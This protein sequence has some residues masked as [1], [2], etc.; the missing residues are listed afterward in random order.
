MIDLAF[1]RDRVVC[2]E[3]SSSLKA[4]IDL[5]SLES[6]RSRWNQRLAGRWVVPSL[7]KALFFCS[8]LILF[9]SIFAGKVRKKA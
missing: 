5:I 4:D 6:M 7:A 3:H 1:N 8:N 9:E 2:R